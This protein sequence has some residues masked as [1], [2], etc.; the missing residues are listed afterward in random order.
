MFIYSTAMKIK[1]LY[2]LYLVICKFLTLSNTTINQQ[3]R[4]HLQIHFFT[5]S[6]YFQFLL[7]FIDFGQSKLVKCK[8]GVRNL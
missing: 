5:C 1:K 2:H 6:F 4:K 7:D 8:F 3:V